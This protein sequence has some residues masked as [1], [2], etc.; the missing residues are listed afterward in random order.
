MDCLC[1][2]LRMFVFYYENNLISLHYRKIYPFYRQRI[3]ELWDY[4]LLINVTSSAWFSVCSTCALQVGWEKRC[5]VMR[6]I[7]YCG[8]N[9]RDL[10]KLLYKQMWYDYL[11]RVHWYH[12]KVCFD[13]WLGIRECVLP[14]EGWSCQ[15][16]FHNPW[17]VMFVFILQPIIPVFTQNVREA[18]R[19]PKVTRGEL[20]PL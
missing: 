9:V 5:L 6:T 13:L 10:P 16:N 8:E 2:T 4:H 18:F 19:T 14:E 20:F 17:Y 3:W 7:P 11:W 1:H 15:S 12:F